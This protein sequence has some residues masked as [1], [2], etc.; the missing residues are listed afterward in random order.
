[1]LRTTVLEWIWKRRNISDTQELLLL[2]LM[3]MMLIIPDVTYQ[4]NNS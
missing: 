3:H 1:M 2:T 4:Q